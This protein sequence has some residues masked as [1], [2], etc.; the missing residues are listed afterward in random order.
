MRKTKTE[1]FVLGSFCS[2]LIIAIIAYFCLSIN[3]LSGLVTYL[4]GLSTVGILLLT[5]FYVVY[6]NKQLNEIQKQRKL[7]VQPLPNI[8]ISEG[9]ILCPRLVHKR[10]HESAEYTFRVDVDFD[11]TIKN[12][13]NGSAILTDVFHDLV[14][15]KIRQGKKESILAYRINTIETG[16]EISFID[17]LD[18]DDYDY[19]IINTLNAIPETECPI[20]VAF[21]IL[22]RS[23]VLY[24]NVLGASF[25]LKIDNIISIGDENQKT[26]SE[27][28]S[29]MSS[30]ENEFASALSKFK[31]VWRRN[32]DEAHEIL[33]KIEDEVATKFS[34]K[35][36]PIDLLAYS[37]SF[38]VTHI[39]EKKAKEYQSKIYHATP[40]GKLKAEEEEKICADVHE[41]AKGL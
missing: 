14:G 16:K 36:I 5:S 27:W 24:K 18:D 7:Q 31:T 35:E 26:L 3:L 28:L 21:D 38:E 22:L 23:M 2:I 25:L 37:P 11:V 32:K 41:K 9:K 4:S 17:T 15:R 10:I 39:S 34:E 29:I 40:I 8:E 13:G 1:Y 6:T 30:F 33:K 12:I 20:T 19:Q